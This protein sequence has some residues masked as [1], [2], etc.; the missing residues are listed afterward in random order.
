[1]VAERRIMMGD[2]IAD[3]VGGRWDNP[4]GADNIALKKRL[5]DISEADNWKEARKE[6]KATGNVGIFH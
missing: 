3:A 4:T 1:M 6:W 5:T 2:I